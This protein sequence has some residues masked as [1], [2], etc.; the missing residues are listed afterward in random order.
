MNLRLY[1]RVHLP[2]PPP[3]PPPPPSVSMEESERGESAGTGTGEDEPA[4]RRR[5]KVTQRRRC[6]RGFR[7]VVS[8]LTNRERGGRSAIGGWRVRRDPNDDGEDDNDDDRDGYEVDDDDDNDD[9]IGGEEN[10][11]SLEDKEAEGDVEAPRSVVTSSSQKPSADGP[12]SYHPP[13]STTLPVLDMTPFIP[14]SGYS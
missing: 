13:S 4:K 5:E 14:R 8:I 9:E 7:I 2:P 11:T 6:C 1:H 10:G 12:S 3:P